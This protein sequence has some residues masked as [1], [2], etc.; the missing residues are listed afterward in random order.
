[1]MDER[2]WGDG[3]QVDWSD[4]LTTLENLDL[5]NN[6]EDFWLQMDTRD[7]TEAGAFIPKEIWENYIIKQKHDKLRIIQK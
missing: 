1:M 6:K 5:V 7:L 4:L 3:V 2:H